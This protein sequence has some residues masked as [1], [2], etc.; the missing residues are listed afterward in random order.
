MGEVSGISWTH[1]TF[2]PWAGCTKVSPACDNC[3]AEIETHRY[4]FAEWGPDAVRRTMSAEYW[5]KPLAWNKQA[6]E[7][8]ERRR[9]FCGSWCDVMEENDR[10]TSSGEKLDQLRDRLYDLIEQTEN[11]DWLL[12]TKRPQN[13]R[14]FLPATWLRSPRPNVWGM[15]TVES[16]EYVWRAEELAQTPFVTRGISAEPLLGNVDLMP[17]LAVGKI[18]WVIVGG[19]SQAGARA[20]RPEYARSLRDQCLQTSVAFH[21]KQWG[22]HDHGLVKVGKHN[23]GRML[24]GRL[25]D[26]IPARVE[27]PIEAL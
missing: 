1:A 2:N 18:D 13:F 17:W 26:E 14:R 9:V 4:K 25:W 21:F 3:Y 27:Y 15:T 6:A 16:Q 20:M 7:A 22:E 5:R 24:D 8:G 23:A 12:L 19:E 11:L 10:T